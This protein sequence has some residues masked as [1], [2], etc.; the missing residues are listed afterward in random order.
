L[1]DCEQNCDGNLI[2]PKD[3]LDIIWT[4]LTNCKSIKDISREKEYIKDMEIKTEE[5]CRILK[6]IE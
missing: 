2:I 6:M 1:Y 3:R 5:W 4:T